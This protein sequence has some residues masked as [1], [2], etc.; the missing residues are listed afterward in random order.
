MQEKASIPPA[1][2]CKDT[3]YEFTK[4]L[5][6]IFAIDGSLDPDYSYIEGLMK[7][8]AENNG[9]ILDG[10]FDWKDNVEKPKQDYAKSYVN[11]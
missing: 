10:N 5:E 8:A 9:V 3:P 11:L 1:L 7:K 4:I 6:Y 2:L